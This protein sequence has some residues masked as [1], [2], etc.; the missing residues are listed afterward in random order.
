MSADISLSLI[1]QAATPGIGLVALGLAWL[2][3]RIPIRAIAVTLVSLGIALL[4]LM[5]FIIVIYNT[6]LVY[7]QEEV[8]LI[9]LGLTPFIY[10]ISLILFVRRTNASAIDTTVFGVLGLIPLWFFGG[11]VLIN[12][13]CSFAAGGC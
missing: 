3:L 4:A 6:S 13:V 11:F 1:A 9:I 5:F 7:A 12:S 8:V 10:V 2:Y